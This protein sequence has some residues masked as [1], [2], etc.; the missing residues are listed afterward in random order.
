M[1][2]ERK[3]KVKLPRR[4]QADRRDLHRPVVPVFSVA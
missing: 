3:R 1:K 2:V 4:F